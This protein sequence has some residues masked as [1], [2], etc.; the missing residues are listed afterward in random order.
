MR[1]YPHFNFSNLS[2]GEHG[3][4][5][6]AVCRAHLLKSCVQL[7]LVRSIQSLCLV[8]ACLFLISSCTDDKSITREGTGIKSSKRISSYRKGKSSKQQKGKPVDRKAKKKSPVSTDLKT[9]EKQIS[10]LQV[11]KPVIKVETGKLP[12]ISADQKG[13]QERQYLNLLFQKSRKVFL[14]MKHPLGYHRLTWQSLRR[15]VKETVR[16]TGFSSALEQSSL[17]WVDF[18]EKESSRLISLYRLPYQLQSTRQNLKLG[19]IKSGDALV[20]PALQS[21]WQHCKLNVE[22]R[23]PGFSLKLISGY[24]SPAYEAVRLTRSSASL[25]K[26]L[27]A[28]APPYFNR[29]QRGVPDIT[30]ELI[31]GKGA[32]KKG[33]EWETLSQVCQP[34]GFT[35]TLVKAGKNEGELG[36]VG[37]EQLYRSTFSSDLIPPR[38]KRDFF[39]AMT[40][41]GFYPSPTG[42]RVLFAISAQESS[43]SWNPRLNKP[44]KAE[45]RNKFNRILENIEAGFGG[46]VS[47]MFFSKVL[48]KE[49]NRLIQELRRITDPGNRRIREYDFYLWTL[50]TRHF[51]THLLEENRNLT[52]FGQWLFKIKQFADQI[53]YEPQT[54]GLWQIN[55][56][57]LI[58][59]IE[60][61]HQLRRRFPEIFYKNGEL[62]KVDRARM[63]DI[64]SGKSNSVLDRQR[65]LELIIHTYLQP[66]YQRHLLGHQDDLKFF[67]AE[68]VAGEMSTFRAAIQQQLNERMESGLILDG[69]LSFYH[70]YSTRIDLKRA[71]NTQNAFRKF[72]Q[73]R[74]PYFKRPVDAEKLLLT[75]CEASSWEQLQRSELYRR[76][77][78]KKRGQRIFPEIKSQL[79]QQ[80][81]RTYAEI[82]LKKSKLF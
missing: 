30:I 69:D 24:R 71:S 55:V 72:I 58:E 13:D 44:K 21:M 48:I 79:Y 19:F 63:I 66:R 52:R 38:T 49:K 5:S 53:Q 50:K 59:R 26:S 34:F 60:D 29:H 15:M 39:N 35:L 10:R 9:R 56:N 25:E 73:L 47:D 42:L 74:Y 77:M 82:V 11:K 65:T 75:L 16:E 36:F 28:I 61:H 17:Q 3:S 67:I 14:A 1:L 81:P 8:L 80:T 2:V 78:K 68:N 43:V 20:T 64:L 32:H 31:T 41:T 46:K 54:F 33:R 23:L 7:N 45:I 27:K 62:W 57:H 12:A 40:K 22:D 18:L 37:I 4:G 6:K 51:L 70:P 76:I